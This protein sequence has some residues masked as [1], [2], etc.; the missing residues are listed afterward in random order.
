MILQI[1]WTEPQLAAVTGFNRETIRK[2]LIA[3]KPI[4]VDEKTRFYG[5]PECFL[6]L[7]RGES[8]RE[9][10]DAAK[11]SR[12]ERKDR[13]ESGDTIH[14]PVVFSTWENIV[15]AFRE[16]VLRIGNNVQSKARLNDE[17]R[18]AV[19]GECADT[20]KELEKKMNYMALIEDEK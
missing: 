16:R 2:R 19:D 14:G 5:A 17:Q 11:A 10:L 18:R 9:R 3:L 4:R 12:E 7:M 13:M 6:K 8:A 20:L 15:V 1:E